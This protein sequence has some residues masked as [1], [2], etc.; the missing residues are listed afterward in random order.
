MKD[1]RAKLEGLADHAV[2]DD[3]ITYPAKTISWFLREK[4]F[5]ALCYVIGSANFKDCPRQAGFQILDGI[6]CVT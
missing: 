6:K 3:D 5:D 4:K 1:Y 2:T